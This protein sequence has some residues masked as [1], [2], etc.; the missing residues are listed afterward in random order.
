[1]AAFDRSNVHFHYHKL[2][3]GKRQIWLMVLAGVGTNGVLACA[4]DS[5]SLDKQPP[6][7]ALPCV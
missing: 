3:L 6:Y 7:V 2:E 4:L 5:I 1:M